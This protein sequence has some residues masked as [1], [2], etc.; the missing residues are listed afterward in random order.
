MDHTYTLSNEGFINPRVMRSLQPQTVVVRNA[1]TLELEEMTLRLHND[2]PDLPVGQ[3]VKVWLQRWFHCETVEFIQRKDAESRQRHADRVAHIALIRRGGQDAYLAPTE[4]LL[5]G[6]PTQQVLK[7]HL[8]FL[9]GELDKQQLEYRSHWH[10]RDP[11]IK[12]KSNDAYDIGSI[13]VTSI[14]EIS[15]FLF[16]HVGSQ[17]A[18]GRIAYAYSPREGGKE[19][20]FSPGR[21]H[22]QLSEP[23]SAG[24]LKRKAGDALCRP[25]NKFWDL[26][27]FGGNRRV[28]CR[29]CLVRMLK[30]YREDCALVKSASLTDECH[31]SVTS[32][33]FGEDCDERL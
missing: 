12:Q 3:P 7:E 5:K 24:R 11:A 8:A 14:G 32:N 25:S 29:Q 13:L 6:C 15:A 23:F 22:F 26:T 16:E 20:F 17:G 10:A 31:D 1:R 2:E 18:K 4:S 28:N 30:L 27:D 9:Y 19:G 33:N 21:T